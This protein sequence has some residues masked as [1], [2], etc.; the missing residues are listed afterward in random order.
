MQIDDGWMDGWRE[1][2]RDDGCWMDGR[3]EGGMDRWMIDDR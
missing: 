1:E 2:G 3:R